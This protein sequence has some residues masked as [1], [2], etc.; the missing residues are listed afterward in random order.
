MRTQW[1]VSPLIICVK[2]YFEEPSGYQAYLCVMRKMHVFLWNNHK[3]HPGHSVNN[4]VVASLLISA[5][6]Q[7]STFSEAIEGSQ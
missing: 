1:Q 4:K 5:V 6:F 3:I 7:G 2:G